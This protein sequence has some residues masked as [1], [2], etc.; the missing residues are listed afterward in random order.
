MAASNVPQLTQKDI[1]RVITTLNFRYFV[2]QERDLNNLMDRFNLDIGTISDMKEVLKQDISIGDQ[3]EFCCQLSNPTLALKFILHNYFPQHVIHYIDFQ[4]INVTYDDVPYISRFMNDCKSFNLQA[5]KESITGVPILIREKLLPMTIQNSS[6]FLEVKM[7]SF[8]A[9]FP[10]YIDIRIK[11]K[12]SILERLSYMF[13]DNNKHI[14]HKYIRNIGEENI[15]NFLLNQY[16]LIS[17]VDNRTIWQ[18]IAEEYG[19]LRH[20]EDYV[21]DYI[22]N[23]PKPSEKTTEKYLVSKL[24]IVFPYRTHQEFVDKLNVIINGK[25]GMAVF[26]PL[27]KGYRRFAYLNKPSSFLG[28]IGRFDETGASVDDLIDSKSAIAFGSTKEYGI[29]SYGVLDAMWRGNESAIIPWE[30]NS[31]NPGVLDTNI[32]EL[33]YQMIQLD[34]A[35]DIVPP[36]GVETRNSLERFV[37]Q[38]IIINVN[39]D[40]V[41]NN[42][43][44]TYDNLTDGEKDQVVEIFKL[45]LDWGFYTRGWRGDSNI[46]PIKTEHTNPFTKDENAALAS[47][48]IVILHEKLD[49]SHPNIK[50]M[51]WDAPLYRHYNGEFLKQPNTIG[52]DIERIA[53][54]ENTFAC[55]RMSSHAIVASAYYYLNLMSA[56]NWYRFDINQLDPIA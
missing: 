15:D 40:D 23:H 3:Y 49:N 6:H 54:N 7:L 12:V 8:L 18:N 56:A 26:R 30:A 24:K 44:A 46:L 25:A 28:S 4:T 43:L 47:E 48:R 42:W 34:K 17:D 52:E 13:G 27:T 21:K 5:V 35:A 11:R 39:R 53:R 29:Y 37:R 20:D 31:N 9:H 36:E 14:A 51:L 45:Y 55:I 10:Q 16:H 32:L 19:M 2:N 38:R 33:V 1:D 50:R 41:S 22:L